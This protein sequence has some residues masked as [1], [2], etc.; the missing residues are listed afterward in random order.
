MKIWVFDD[1]LFWSSRLIGSLTALGH[2]ASTIA[3]LPADGSRA[4]VALINLAT[5]GNR[6]AELVSAL[7]GR[8]VRTIGFAGHKE[9]ELLELGKESGCDE[10]ATNSEITFK[11]NSILGRTFPADA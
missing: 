6:V 4:D 3:S 10:V 9:K 7:R 8:G 2:E 11:L 5:Q 1:N